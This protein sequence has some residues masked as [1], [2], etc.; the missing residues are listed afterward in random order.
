MPS[1]PRNAVD[2]GVGVG[3]LLGPG[4][5]GSQPPESTSKCCSSEAAGA[6]LPGVASGAPLALLSL[7]N[8]CASP[9]GAIGKQ[10]LAPMM[11]GGEAAACRASARNEVSGPRLEQA[12]VGQCEPVVAIAL[13]RVRHGARWEY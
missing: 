9:A 12:W 6:G 13:I 7:P 5:R 10:L 8:V 4:Y 11:S 3:A 2:G 1:K